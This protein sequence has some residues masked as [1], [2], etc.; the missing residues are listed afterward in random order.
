MNIWRHQ[1]VCLLRCR[2]CAGRLGL[3]LRPLLSVDLICKGL[4]RLY[5]PL[6]DIYS[7]SLVSYL[8]NYAYWKRSREAVIVLPGDG[9]AHVA[10]VNSFFA[11]IVT[12]EFSLLDRLCDVIMHKL[13]KLVSYILLVVLDSLLLHELFNDLNQLRFVNI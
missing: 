9:E 13:D 7:V 5:R 4:H 8:P 3:V 2:Q 10:D 11:C 1:G 12:V 6:L